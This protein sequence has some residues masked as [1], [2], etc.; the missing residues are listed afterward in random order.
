MVSEEPPRGCCGCVTESV[1]D[2]VS[3]EQHGVGGVSPTRR[4]PNHL[5][6]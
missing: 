4:R 2:C 6:F 1:K 5:A 3:V